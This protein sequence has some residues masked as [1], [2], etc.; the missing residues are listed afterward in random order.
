MD[1]LASI[2]E[3]DE[4]MLKIN[5]EEIR[6]EMEDMKIIAQKKTRVLKI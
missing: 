4:A 5:I 3:S 6:I 2:L 1:N